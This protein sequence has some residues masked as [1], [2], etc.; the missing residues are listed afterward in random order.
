M[1]IL[2]LLSEKEREKV[3]NFQKNVTFARQKQNVGL[4]KKSVKYACKN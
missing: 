3:G 2:I 1:K 4:T